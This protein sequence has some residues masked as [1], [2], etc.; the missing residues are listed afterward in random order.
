MEPGWG[1]LF[2]CNVPC[3]R[4]LQQFHSKWCKGEKLARS[5]PLCPLKK[6]TPNCFLYF[7]CFLFKLLG[8][9]AGDLVIKME[10]P[11]DTG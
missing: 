2:M 7:A 11:Q 4:Y 8:S 9:Q 6:K 5:H 1:P 3:D 10:L